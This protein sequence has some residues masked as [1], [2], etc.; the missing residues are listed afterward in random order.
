MSIHPKSEAESDANTMA[1]AEAIKSDNKRL[2]KAKTAAARMVKEQR[3]KTAALGKLA[4]AKVKMTK[5][6]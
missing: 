5:R 1:E 3:I 4:N 6:S 2:M